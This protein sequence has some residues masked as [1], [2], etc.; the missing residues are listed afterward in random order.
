[1]MNEDIKILEKKALYGN[2]FINLLDSEQWKLLDE[3]IFKPLDRS[4]FE[5][6]KKVEPSDVNGIIEVQ[7]IS[8]VIDKIKLEISIKIN[9]GVFAKNQLKLMAEETEE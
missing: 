3:E 2:R 6:F 7:M 5:T 1:M 9:E 4:A 8:K